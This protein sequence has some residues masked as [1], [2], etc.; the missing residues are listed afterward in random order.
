MI[1]INRNKKSATL[2]TFV[3]IS[4]FFFF[5]NGCTQMGLGEAEQQLEPPPPSTSELT[6]EN[7]PYYP[8]EFK[9]LLIPSELS[10]NRENSMVIKTDSFAG[11]I[12]N[13]TGRVE[14]N[15]LADFFT[16]SMVKSNWKL[17]GSVKYKNIMLVFTKPYKTCTI[18]ISESDFGTKTDVNVYIT[19][20]L[21]GGMP[22]GSAATGS[23]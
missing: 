16:S 23:F 13:F 6:T 8:T 7:Q 2:L 11:G 14:I 15:S 10:W 1:S 22:L 3:G 9:D 18:V 20:D 17:S 21:T 19:D 12:L 5:L 4:I